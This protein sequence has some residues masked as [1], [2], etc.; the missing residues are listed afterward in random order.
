MDETCVMSK[1]TAGDHQDKVKDQVHQSKAR[2]V[3]SVPFF[4]INGKYSISGAQ[5]AET[6]A[7]AFD[8]IANA[9]T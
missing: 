6:L 1:L 3:S 8:Q 9:A 4:V 5:P 2:G 7:S